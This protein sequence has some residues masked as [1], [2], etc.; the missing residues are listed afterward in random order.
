MKKWSVAVPSRMSRFE[1]RHLQDD[2]IIAEL[3]NVAVL[4]SPMPIDA[5][6]RLAAHYRRS[7]DQLSEE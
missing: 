5:V 6:R 2:I 7:P 3:A 4:A 1:P